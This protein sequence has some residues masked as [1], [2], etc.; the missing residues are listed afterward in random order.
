MQKTAT[1][2]GA[3]VGQAEGPYRERYQAG[4]ALRR[5]T[6][7]EAL[8][9]FALPGAETQKER[10]PVAILREGDNGR[11]PS[12]LKLRHDRMAHSAF[13]FYRGAPI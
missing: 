4:K 13:A 12:L 5:A 10:D 11:L 8:A 1:T 9:D 2:N 7:R 6:S 3:S